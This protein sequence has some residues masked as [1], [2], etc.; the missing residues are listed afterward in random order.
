MNPSYI[1]GVFTLDGESELNLQWIAVTF[2]GAVQ[3]NVTSSVIE[4]TFAT[5]DYAEGIYEIQ[6]IGE[7]EAG[8]HVESEIWEYDF[9][10]R[11][12]LSPVL[13]VVIVV[14]GIIVL[15]VILNKRKKKDKK[16][17]V[18]IDP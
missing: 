15:L 6:L 3:K 2:N 14:L 4:Y 17:E 13:I 18:K 9:K 1:A 11:S 8:I 7:T 12:N 10:H 16:I 5:D